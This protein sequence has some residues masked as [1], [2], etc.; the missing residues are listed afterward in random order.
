MLG[1]IYYRKLTTLSDELERHSSPTV[2]MLR[3]LLIHI[4]FVSHLETAM[5]KNLQD[6]TEKFYNGY[7]L[8]VTEIYTDARQNYF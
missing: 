8:Q 1:L 3:C 7:V 6:T 5:W 4:S 2:V